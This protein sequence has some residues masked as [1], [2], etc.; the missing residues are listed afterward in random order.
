MKRRKCICARGYE[1]REKNILHHPEKLF[2]NESRG[3]KT[4]YALQRPE[5]LVCFDAVRIFYY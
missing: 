1:E 3:K 2:K 5:I 4:K